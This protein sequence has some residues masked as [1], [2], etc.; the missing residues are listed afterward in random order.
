MRLPFSLSGPYPALLLALACA[1][2]SP[3]D[4]ASEPTAPPPDS[5]PLEAP[6]DSLRLHGEFGLAVHMTADSTV[7]VRW[8]TRRRG[9][10]RLEIR[11]DGELLASETTPS[12]T[13][14]V[15][16]FPH[17]QR[18]DPAAGSF[19]VDYGSAHDPEDRHTTRIHLDLDDRIPPVRIRGVDTLFV[20]ADIHGEY[21]RMVAL[22]QNAGIIDANLRWVGGRSHLAVLGDMVSRGPDA[23]AILWFLYRLERE[24]EAAGGAVHITLGNHEIMVMLADLRYVHGKEL[25]IA[26]SHGLPY[27]R[28]LDPRYSVLGRWL[29]SKP[30]VIQV[31][32]ALMTHGGASPWFLPY[33]TESHRDSLSSFVDED[34][35]YR[36][37]D[38]TWVVDLDS[39]SFERRVEFFWAPE[40]T[41]WFRGYAESDSLDAELAAILQH[42][43]A[44]VH[45]VGHTPVPNIV[46]AYDGR[47]I[48]VNTIPFAT[49]LL[50]RVSTPTGFSYQRVL[51]EGEPIPLLTRPS[52]TPPPPP[53]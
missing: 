13:A 16:T 12:G 4:V 38:T 50:R 17:P 28:M 27:D 42:T 29:A 49:E 53:P 26:Q 14:H 11:V 43:G 20:V 46:E 31:D 40:S 21:D 39:V 1:S 37:A 34:L 35:F 33:S 22:F 51:M 6:A 7:E 19:Q 32:D 36:W 52:L 45:I 5:L 47:L 2:S 23:T 18:H 30:A 10:G 8:L 3:P 15:H 41:F 48:M 25:W 9:A 24:A 44:R